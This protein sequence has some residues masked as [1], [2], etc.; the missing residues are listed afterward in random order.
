[1]NLKNSFLAIF[2]EIAQTALISLGIFLVVY[3]FIFQP[4]RVKGESMIPSFQDGEL[5][6]TEKVSYRFSE[7]KRG[8]VVI[9]Q[10][11]SS[12]NVDF[13]KR[14]IGLP[15]ETVNFEGGKVKINDKLLEEEYVNSSTQ[16][17]GTYRLSENEYLVL[18]DNRNQSSDSRAFGPIKKDTI[19]GRAWLVYWPIFKV[20]TSQGARIVSRINYGITDSFNNF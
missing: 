1:M 11:P 18:G 6:L 16:G 5:L 4:H 17:N 9:F 12:R 13:I 15:G 3:L 7:P 10:A 20:K 2:K 14:V 8:D 19:E